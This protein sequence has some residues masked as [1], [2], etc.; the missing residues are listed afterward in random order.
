MRSAIRG[1]VRAVLL[2]FV[3]WSAGSQ[4]LK[5]AAEAQRETSAS[6]PVA[7]LNVNVVPMDTERILE[8]QTV[9]VRDGRIADLG[10]AD[11]VEIPADAERIEAEGCYLMPA[12]ADLHT[13]FVY[14]PNWENDLFLFVANGVTSVREMWGMSPFLTWR[15]AIGRGAV[16]GPTLYLASTGLD[17]PGGYWSALT[18]PIAWPDQARQAVASYKAAGYDFIKV[19]SDLRPEVYAAIIEEAAAQGIKVVGHVPTRVGLLDVLA[20]QQYSIEHFL[21]IVELVSSNRALTGVVDEERLREVAGL[22]REA[23]VWVS[24]TLTVSTVSLDQVA[25]LAQRPEMRYASHQMKAWFQHPTNQAPNRDLSRPVAN[26]KLMLKGLNDAGAKLLLGVD[27]GIRYVLPGFSIHDELRLRVEAGLTPYEVI[28]MGTVNA[29]EFLNR[30]EETG[31][32]AV[33][34]RADLVLLQGNPLAD[35][36]N[37]DKRVGVMAGGRWLSET[38][39]R[40]RLEQIAQSYGN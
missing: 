30:Q 21:G 29:A 28:R 8:R 24:P 4:G 19:Y 33:G 1:G 39:L 11:S 34:K 7:F 15:A 2:A 40:E 14:G 31:S 37:I 22:V 35:V 5:L 23:G 25:G 36:A 13:H 17:G 26:S 38:W 16:L 12:L 20:A 10:P 6:V 9:V 27:S 3:L 32:V 18:P